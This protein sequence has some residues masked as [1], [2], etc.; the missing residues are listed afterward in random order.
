[1]KVEQSFARLAF[2]LNH[3]V[4]AFRMVHRNTSQNWRS[5]D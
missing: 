2:T 4:I 1:M 5:W 3:Q